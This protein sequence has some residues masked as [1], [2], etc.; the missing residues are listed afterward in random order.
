M[1]VGPQSTEQERRDFAEKVK[2]NPRNYIAQPVVAQSR[3][4]VVA[5]DQLEGLHLDLRPFIHYGEE[6]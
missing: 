2:A 4:P 5:N 1:L 6:I 3:V